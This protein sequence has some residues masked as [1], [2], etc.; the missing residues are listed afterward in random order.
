M[1]IDDCVDLDVLAECAG[2]DVRTLRDLNPE[3][4]Q[5]C[6]PPGEKAYRLRIPS[7]AGAHFTDAYAKVPDSM[8]RDWIVHTVRRG[9]TLGGIAARYGVTSGI[10]QE[11]NRLKSTRVLSVGSTLVIPVPK[12]SDRHAALVAAS[13]ASEPARTISRTRAVPTTARMQRAL[14]QAA[15]RSPDQRDGKVQLIYR[16]KRGDTIGH[17]AEWYEVRAADIRNWNDIAY[18]RFIR[19][20]QELEVYV[21]EKDASRLKNIDRLTFA[22]KQS[23][24][25]TGDPDGDA[26]ADEANYTVRSGDTLDEIARDHG[27]SVVQIKRWNN[28][29]SS[30]IRAGDRLVIHESAENMRLVDAKTAATKPADGK[31]VIYVVKRGDT[32]W[33]IAKAYA[34]T[35]DDLRAWNDLGKNSIR[36]GQELVIHRNGN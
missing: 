32:L 21:S 34:V 6:T 1:T 18:G 13:S 26:G 24:V 5:W 10:L 11:T 22:E 4:L 3:L 27:V 36:A 8:K 30:L 29:R 14:A 16:V 9:E 7:G 28:L 19:P 23:R 17:I 2:T 33:D 25:N 20:G 15:Q 12:G 35:P 31:M